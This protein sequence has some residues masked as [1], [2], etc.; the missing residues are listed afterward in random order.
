MEPVPKKSGTKM[1]EDKTMTN[2][3]YS[4]C[5][6]TV[7][8]AIGIIAGGCS[9]NDSNDPLEPAKVQKYHMVVNAA[10]AQDNPANAPR[11]V[12]GLDGNTLNA[13]WA[14]GE[15][16]TVYN[17]TKNTAISGVLTAL[18]NGASTT[19]SG[20]LTGNIEPSDVLTLRFLSPNY[21]GQD[22]TLEYI[23]SHCDYAE[24]SVTVASVSGSTIT[25]TADAVFENMQAIVKF[26]LISK[27]DG[28]TL[29]NPTA[30]TINDGTNDIIT[31]SEI[32]TSTYTTNSDGV[33]YVAMPSFA[34]KT[35]TL[36][37][38]QESNVY[39]F[40]KNDVTFAN[41]NFYSITTKMREKIHNGALLGE[42][43]VSPTKKVRFARGNLQYNAALGIHQCADGTPKQGTWRF[44]E[45][46]YDTIG[47]SQRNRSSSYDGWIDS[48]AWGTS[49]WNSGAVI[50]QPW[51]LS[52]SYTDCF[53]G[54]SSDNGLTGEFKYAD[55][56][57]YNAISNGGNIP[58]TWRVLSA[59]E[60]NYLLGERSNHSNLCAAAIV[61]GISGKIILPD[62]FI[63]PEGIPFVGF[64]TNATENQYSLSEWT[65]LENN[66]A[67]FLP[68]TV[69]WSSTSG[70]TEW[71]ELCG[72]YW[73]STPRSNTE[74][75]ALGIVTQ[76]HSLYISRWRCDSGCVRPVQDV[77]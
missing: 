21:T 17:E 38:L 3:I 39:V 23:S 65:L 29:L 61:N 18:S 44:A 16:V 7:M 69:G 32:P 56:G 60:W 70:I 4:A 8:L 13:S 57:V 53:V 49:G 25:P 35:I 43:S 20:D 54:N 73:S 55:W 2:K 59:D 52:N 30:L 14:V 26:T 48:Y 33:L 47:L 31:L 41:S 72:M 77:E 37:A 75:V 27:T 9:K 67:V 50:Y 36:T 51:E 66:G 76:T 15:E 71:Q 12:L 68:R 22:G 34:G 10:K 24:A 28:S 42:F 6:T 64:S 74:I 1:K 58:N 62:N 45:N 5:M 11:R 19:L 46:Q 63:F 40:T